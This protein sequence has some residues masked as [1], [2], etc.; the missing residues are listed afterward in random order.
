MINDGEV[1]IKD[2]EMY[3]FSK[4]IKIQGFDKYKIFKGL[5]PTRYMNSESEEKNS[6]NAQKIH[7]KI[8][9]F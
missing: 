6:I 7:P 1:D 8:I 9:D 5:I 3:E 2:L 4:K